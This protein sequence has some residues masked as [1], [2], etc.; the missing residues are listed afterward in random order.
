ME[1][2]ATGAE[3]AIKNPGL[4]CAPSGLRLAVPTPPAS[5]AACAARGERPLA[6]PIARPVGAIMPQAPVERA[7]G[8]LEAAAGARARTR[9]AAAAR[10]A[11][12]ASKPKR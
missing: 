2:S 3:S 9:P 12:A 6:W 4:R 8:E 11:F 1:R 5:R 7:V 10:P